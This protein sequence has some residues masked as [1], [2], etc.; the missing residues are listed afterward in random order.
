MDLSRELCTVAIL[1]SSACRDGRLP[2]LR[3]PLAARAL[4]GLRRCALLRQAVPAGCLARACAV[5]QAGPRRDRPRAADAGGDGRG[6]PGARPRRPGPR[7]R[8]RGGSE[9]PRR[10]GAPGLRGKYLSNTTCLTQVSS[11]AANNLTN[12][13]DP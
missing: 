6:G 9:A 4:H 12:Y 3:R 5:L 13:G 2:G 11:K 7:G 8:P 1:G 10:A